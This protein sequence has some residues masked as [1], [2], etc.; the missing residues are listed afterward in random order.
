MNK[1]LKRAV[2]HVSVRKNEGITQKELLRLLH[3]EFDELFT[4]KD[5]DMIALIQITPEITLK[6][7]EW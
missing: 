6:N 7:D 4:F 1:L 5:E 3:E 2:F